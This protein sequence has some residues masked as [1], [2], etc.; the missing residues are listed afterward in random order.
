LLALKK[1]ASWWDRERFVRDNDWAKFGQASNSRVGN[2]LY[3][4]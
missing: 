3:K 4:L 1:V 2:Q